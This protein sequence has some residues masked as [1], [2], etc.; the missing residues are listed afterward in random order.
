MSEKGLLFVWCLIG[1]TAF[2]VA[3]CGGGGTPSATSP[4]NNT[5]ASTPT[6]GPSPTPPPLLTSNQVFN[7]VSPSV[8]LISTPTTSGNAILIDGGYLLTNSHVVHGFEQARVVFP[9]GSEFLEVPVKNSDDLID[10]AVLGPINTDIRTLKLHNRED[11]DIGSEV[12]LV[13]N[14]A[15]THDPQPDI[16]R[17]ILSRMR[18]WEAIG[19]TYL[20]T[21][22]ATAGGQSGGALVS[23]RG[24]I[25]G[26][27]GLRFRDG[28][29]GLVASAADLAP[30]AEALIQGRDASVL[31][32]RPFNREGGQLE[33]QFVLENPWDIHT[34]LIDEPVGSDILFQ[35]DGNADGLFTVLDPFGTTLLIG[36][37][38]TPGVKSG[39][40]RIAA[41]GQHSVSVGLASGSEGEF[42]I[43]GDVN[44]IPADDPDDGV[45]L[46]IGD[47]V[48]GDI[49]FIG[50][51]DFFLLDLEEGETVEIRV[52]SMNIDTQLAIDFPN[53]LPNQVLADNDGGGGLS[54]ADSR[55]YYR[56]IQ[57]GVHYLVVTDAALEHT[58]GYFISVNV[59]PPGATAV[60]IPQIVETVDTP[61]GLMFV[62]ESPTSGISAHAPADW[63]TEKSSSPSIELNLVD[64]KDSNII[65]VVE[66][67]IAVGL[68]ETTL[69]EYSDLVVSLFET[70]IPGFELLSQENVQTTQ[71][72]D[73][74]RIEYL[75][76]QRD[77]H[78]SRLIIFDDNNLAINFSIHTTSKQYEIMNEMI[79]YIFDSF[80]SD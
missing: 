52:E 48:A 62:F 41:E 46:S 28:D 15:G 68:G 79:D 25:V 13:G 37:S 2:L 60:E 77:F 76:R 56:P 6:E 14:P 75:A 16:T 61:Y 24:E 39:I 67:L 73:A 35:L 66:D 11:L 51:V 34:F 17:G 18:E 23:E 21:D 59:A 69:N 20:Q 49:D 10:L 54:G 19:I 64:K 47:L 71:G 31:G 58:G 38:G 44:F 78:G 32:S 3:A 72:L 36:D 53:S 55:M 33:H 26:I 7:L 63:R 50:D 9:D 30:L 4:G 43:S 12:Y 70:Q 40:F 45:A 42:T 5:Q 80:R 74:V 27:S 57:T 22:A 1:L 65:I 29:F 8:A